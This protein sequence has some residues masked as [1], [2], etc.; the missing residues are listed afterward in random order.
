MSL[1]PAQCR[2]ARGLVNWSQTRLAEEAGVSRATVTS[3][4]AEKRIPIG[5]NLDAIRSALEVAGVD[6]IPENGGGAGVRMRIP[7]PK[8]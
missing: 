7:C 2:A 3:F 6:F 4:E 1:L 8:K 5:N